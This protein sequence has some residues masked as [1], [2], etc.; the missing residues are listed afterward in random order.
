M[1]RLLRA[2][3]GSTSDIRV[4]SAGVNAV[5][6]APIPAL[7]ASLVAK[8]GADPDGFVARQLTEQMIRDADLVLALT[9]GHRSQIVSLHPG[10]VRHAF[11]LRELARLASAVDPAA[12]PSGSHATRLAAL[13]PL[14]AAQRGRRPSEPGEDDVVDPYGGDAALYERSFGELHPAVRAIARLV[15]G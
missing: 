10:A 1:E 4:T 5:V 8:A 9:K 11:T 6:G 2:D 12:I 14:A 7:M 15:R 13:L 3:L